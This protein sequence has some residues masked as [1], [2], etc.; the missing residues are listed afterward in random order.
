MKCK[1]TKANGK[2]Q[3]PKYLKPFEAELQSRRVLCVSV[4][5]VPTEL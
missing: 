4:V 3:N 5:S 2:L 1:A